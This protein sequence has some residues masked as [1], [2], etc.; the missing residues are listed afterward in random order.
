MGF[1]SEQALSSS[2]PSPL[3][4]WVANSASR[5]FSPQPLSRELSHLKNVPAY[6][7]LNL[8]NFESA[9]HFVFMPPSTKKKVGGGGGSDGSL[10]ITFQTWASGQI[11]LQRGG[12]EA[13]WLGFPGSCQLRSTLAAGGE[14]ATGQG[15]TCHLYLP[16]GKMASNGPIVNL[17][18]KH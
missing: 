15:Y 18:K 3:W 17:N 16:L 6:Y 10:I 7:Q 12:A 8:D 11:P 2:P 9:S 1:G 4:G 5:V 13:L 14:E